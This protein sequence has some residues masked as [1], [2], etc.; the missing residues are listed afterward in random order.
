MPCAV[1]PFPSLLQVDFT[2]PPR[3]VSANA[4]P[5][6]TTSSGEIID[7]ELTEAIDPETFRE[8]LASK[9]PIDLPIYSVEPV[10]VSAPAST[11]LL[12]KAE[13]QIRVDSA[14]VIS[15]AQ[16]HEW[17]EAIQTKTEIW[18][19]QTTKSGKVQSVNLRD[20]LFDL[21]VIEVDGLQTVLRYVGSCRNDGTLLRPDHVVYLLEQASQ[22]ELRLLHTHRSQLI[23]SGT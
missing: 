3:I 15:P 13:Y 11:Q 12:E 7:F 8:K 19:E 20:R 17:I 4:L 5:L 1:P 22:Q 14:E 23:L 6:G 21:T 9:L 16:W 10:E 2:L 18:F